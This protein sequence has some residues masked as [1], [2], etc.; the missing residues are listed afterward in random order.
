MTVLFSP[1]LR[2]HRRPTRR[3]DSS[4]G[5]PALALTGFP[6]D[7]CRTGR[8]N[9]VHLALHRLRDLRYRVRPRHVLITNA[10]VSGMPRAQAGVAAAIAS[11]SRQ[12][13]SDAG[14]R[15]D[16]FP[17]VR[18]AAERQ[19]HR[20]RRRQPC[21]LVGPGRPR[22]HRV[23]PGPDRDDIVGPGDSEPNGRGHQ[24]RVPGGARRMTRA[25]ARRDRAA[26]EA[27]QAMADLVLN[28]ER[29]REVSE[30]VG[31]SF[32]K[33]RALR[34]VADARW[35][36]RSGIPL[37]CR[38]AQPDPGRGRPRTGGT[39]GAPAPSH[40]PA[41]EARGCNCAKGAALAQTA[42]AILARPPARLSALPAEEL[43]EP[44]R[45][46]WRLV[47]ADLIPDF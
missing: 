32:G 35:P 34:R 1:D 2:A 25:S 46:Y 40:R 43:E 20:L 23:D 33:I 6:P 30:E 36:C 29:R 3:P 37:T 39:G 10:A 38:S 13:G 5:G 19:S 26:S 45:G 7:A 27:W 44:A 31:L 4:P 17:G 11:T 9:A 16:G 21:R 22:R 24:S 28:N 18:L 8:D 41:C 47:Q 14:R 15:R 42:D 12:I